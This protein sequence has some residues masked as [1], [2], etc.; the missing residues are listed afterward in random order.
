MPMLSMYFM[1]GLIN[2]IS[3]ELNV[4]TDLSFLVSLLVQSL[5]S[6]LECLLVMRDFRGAASIWEVDS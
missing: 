1:N 3:S 4:L 2:E 5:E 6:E